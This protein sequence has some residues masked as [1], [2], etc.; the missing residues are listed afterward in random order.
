M[1]NTNAIISPL[2]KTIHSRGTSDEAN[3]CPMNENN[4]HRS[5]RRSNGLRHAENAS[6]DDRIAIGNPFSRLQ[7]IFQGEERFS[8]PFGRWRR[9]IQERVA[10]TRER[11]VSVDQLGKYRSNERKS[12]AND[13][14]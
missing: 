1:T 9:E 4:T 10:R 11:G 5:T 14:R 8:V 7:I 2:K 13:R 6:L 3:H 12:I